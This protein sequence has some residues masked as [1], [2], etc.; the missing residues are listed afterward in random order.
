[1]GRF[2]DRATQP[3]RGPADLLRWRIRDTITGRR[4]KENDPQFVTPTRAPDLPLIA[5]SAPSLT[6]VGHATFVLRLGGKLIATDPVWSKR[7]AVIE[8]RCP[9]G[10]ALEALPPLDVITVSHNHYDHL[11]APTIARIGEGP[12]YVTPLG[13]GR[14]LHQ[15]GAKNVVELDWWQSHEL[16]GVEITLVPARHWSMRMP[17]NRND[18][19]WGG[20]V[21]RARDGVAYHSG[22][23]ALFDGFTEIARRLGPIDWAMLPIGAYEPRW[24]MEPQHM[25]P[26]DAGE[27]FVRLGARKLCAMHW[28]TFKLTDEPMGEPPRRIRELFVE[29]G[30]AAD[31]LWLFDVGQTRALTP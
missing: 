8:R 12:L 29:R 15:A 3:A 26:E 7:M 14:W 13:N 31:S 18:A 1:M 30:L 2:D 23:T 9:V 5:S 22:D 11:D 6:W 20:F 10:V 19:L 21:Y 28:G 27:A 16:D 25:N 24:F 17:W 4:V